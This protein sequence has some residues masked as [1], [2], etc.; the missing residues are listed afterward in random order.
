MKCVGGVLIMYD[1]RTIIVRTV[2]WVN[3]PYY[4][5]HEVE[6]RPNIL[7][8]L[9]STCLITRKTLIPDKHTNKW[10]VSH[11]PYANACVSNELGCADDPRSM[12]RC[13]DCG[14]PVRPRSARSANWVGWL[15]V[16]APPARSSGY[17]KMGAEHPLHFQQAY[18]LDPMKDSC[19]LKHLRG[20]C[21][22][23]Y[24]LQVASDLR[25]R[26][27]DWRGVPAC[28]AASRTLFD[29]AEHR[30][31]VYISNHLVDQPS[32]AYIY[33]RYQACSPRNCALFPVQRWF[34]SG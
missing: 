27:L 2:L 25:S 29:Y 5:T 30:N 13:D 32:G 15:P 24:N 20:V 22:G 19:F 1:Y 17:Y 9:P 10:Q 3:Y 18:I 21:I 7:Q 14:R 31:R 28:H 23:S 8:C 6:N 16:T 26:L 4:T 11:L 33:D 34:S 12:G